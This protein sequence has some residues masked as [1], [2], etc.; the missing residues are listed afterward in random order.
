MDRPAASRPNLGVLGDLFRDEVLSRL[1]ATDLAM[2]GR[3]GDS[4]LRKDVVGSGLTR[5][6]T[7]NTRLNLV[8]FI[9]S[10]DR[11]SWAVKTS[12]AQKEPHSEIKWGYLENSICTRIAGEGNLEVLHWVLTQKLPPPWDERTVSAALSN[13][14]T[15]ILNWFG[16]VEGERTGFDTLASIDID[17]LEPRNLPL[18]ADMLN[19]MHKLP[20]RETEQQ[21]AASGGHRAML[22]FMYRAGQPHHADGEVNDYGEPLDRDTWM[23]FHFGPPYSFDLDTV[24]DLGL[25]AAKGG[26][27]D[28]LMWLCEG[29][30]Y[31]NW[32]FVELGNAV[33]ASAE[34]T[35]YQQR[36]RAAR[37]GD[38]LDLL[39]KRLDE[40]GLSDEM[41]Y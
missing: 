19:E 37:V 35:S 18:F 2:V 39:E 6:G 8:D 24:L 1:S 10:V 41:Y 26:H 22:E 33:G 40:E 28:A 38:K 30:P 20:D 4:E 12:G 34:G 23:D 31:T 13:G 29:F 16:R 3:V 9:G 32:D 27:G 15:H 5:A 25:R 17:S 11:L 14:H 21:R 36:F 7:A